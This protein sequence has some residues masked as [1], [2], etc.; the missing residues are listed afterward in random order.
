MENYG[1]YKIASSKR[2]NTYVDLACTLAAELD[3]D[4]GVTEVGSHGE[5]GDRHGS[6]DNDSQLVEEPGTSGPLQVIM[7]IDY[8]YQRGCECLPG[9]RGRP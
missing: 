1:Q 3:G 5:V 2:D 9:S 7:S 6:Q 8:A 4:G